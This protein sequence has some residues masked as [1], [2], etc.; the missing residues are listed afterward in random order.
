MYLEKPHFSKKEVNP[1][2]MCDEPEVPLKFIQ[3]KQ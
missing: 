1:F 2:T 3:K